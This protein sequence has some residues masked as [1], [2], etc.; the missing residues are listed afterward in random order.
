MHLLELSLSGAVMILV[1]GLLR[2]ILQH[3]VRREV[4]LALWAIVVLRLLVPV[5]VAS[6]LSVYNLV[7]FSPET[8]AAVV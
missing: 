8:P 6:P 5:T 7:V 2:T 3:R 4:W 1:I